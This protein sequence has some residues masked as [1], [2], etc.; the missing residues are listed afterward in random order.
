MIPTQFVMNAEHDALVNSV[1]NDL[2]KRGLFTIVLSGSKLV[3]EALT[4][5]ISRTNPY[6]LSS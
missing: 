1:A 6:L 3:P 2:A 5:L 4:L